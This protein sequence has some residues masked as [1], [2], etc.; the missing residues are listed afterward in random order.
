MVLRS[1]QF[2]ASG[3]TLNLSRGGARVVL[4]QPV[5]AGAE[6]DVTIG[7]GPSRRGRVV[8]V[9]IEAD[10]EIVGIQYLGTDSEPPGSVPGQP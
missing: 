7:D 2:E 1:G 8:W 4:E 10:G 6:Y 9:Q 3:W 5:Q